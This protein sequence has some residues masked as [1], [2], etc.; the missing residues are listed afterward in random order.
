MLGV[1]PSGCPDSAVIPKTPFSDENGKGSSVPIRG[2]ARLKRRRDTRSGAYRTGL[3]RLLGC[4]P[5]RIER[6]F[7][8]LDAGNY[9]RVEGFALGIWLLRY[10]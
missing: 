6:H 4:A 2:C 10:G 9:N 8:L 5:F 1:H 3:G 7:L